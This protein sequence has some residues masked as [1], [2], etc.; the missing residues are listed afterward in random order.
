ML[1]FSILIKNYYKIFINNNNCNST[2]NFLLKNMIAFR[3]YHFILEQ[4]ISIKSIK[5]TV[6]LDCLKKSC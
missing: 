6:D 2:V 3:I 5:Y 1:T 4:I